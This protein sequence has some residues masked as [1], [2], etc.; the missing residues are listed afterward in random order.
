M[1]AKI[2]EKHFTLNS[3]L[4]GKDHH[5]SLEPSAFKLMVEK[6]RRVEKM[7]G[8][9][10]IGPVKSEKKIEKVFIDILLQRK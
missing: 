10:E 5:I 9:N 3:K 4:K 1:G 7:L 8:T 6:I 2:I